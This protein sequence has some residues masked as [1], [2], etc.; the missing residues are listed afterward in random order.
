MSI[1][2]WVKRYSNQLISIAIA[3]AVAVIAFQQGTA[4]VEALKKVRVGWGL[5][6]LCFYGVNCLLRALRVKTIVKGSL[7]MWPDAVRTA[8]LHGLATYL[9]P[10]RTGDF[11]LPVILNR[12]TGM[13]LSDGAKVLLTIR[14]LDL[15][16]LGWWILLTAV[17]VD[18]QLPLTIHF[19]WA[20]LGI[21]LSLLPL[22]LKW[23]VW[24]GRQRKGR[25]WKTVVD[26]HDGAA[27]SI[28]NLVISLGIWACVGACFYCTAQ[29]IDLRLGLFDV[30]L[31][32]TIQLP[33][34][35]V[36]LQGVAN[37]GNHEGG[38]VAGLSLLGIPADQGL[39]YALI[40][41]ALLLT[42]VLTLGPLVLLIR[43]VPAV[44]NEK[45]V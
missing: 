8:C 22:V 6:G 3:I 45:K 2:Y 5:A 21:A 44:E 36:P 18:I 14:M 4:L 39:H 15:W 9:L 17:I 37:A 19:L 20:A 40:S 13:S 32:I 41:H 34:Q 43:K 31:L 33:L 38:W 12:S 26:W 25:L 10:F 16:A 35:M 28:A 23:G 42:Y 24:I 29:A 30:W 1:L 27:F 7:Q 11:T